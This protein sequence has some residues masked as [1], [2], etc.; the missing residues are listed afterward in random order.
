MYEALDQKDQHAPP[1][2]MEYR[3]EAL[4]TALGEH[5]YCLEEVILARV[6]GAGKKRADYFVS[7]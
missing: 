1:V 7:F 6:Q 4:P 5:F 2:L 3:R